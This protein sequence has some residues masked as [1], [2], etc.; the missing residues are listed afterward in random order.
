MIVE[1]IRK[2]I[3]VGAT[4]PKPKATADFVVKGWGR[5]RGE[6][7]LV[8]FI[9][10]HRDPGRPYEK[11]ITTSDFEKAFAELR[12]S[13]VFTRS[14]FNEHLQ[15]CAKEGAC[16]YTTIGGVFNIL[17]EAAYVRRGTYER[18]T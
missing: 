13:G 17:G 2:G 15:A 8:Y 5:R 10:N 16:N 12:L 3:A 9:P 11:G 18:R 4:I 1:K 14:W 6:H 7:A